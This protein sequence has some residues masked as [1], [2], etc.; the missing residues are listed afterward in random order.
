M[1]NNFGKITLENAHRML[2]Y[3]TYTIVQKYSQIYILRSGKGVYIMRTQSFWQNI[4][5]D[6]TSRLPTRL[7]RNITIKAKYK[8]DTF[9][10]K[11]YLY[12]SDTVLF[13]KFIKTNKYII[14]I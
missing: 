3:F 4:F 9:S 12:I 8:T 13:S 2:D 11:K 14:N 1:D 7:F 6:E 10:R 5:P